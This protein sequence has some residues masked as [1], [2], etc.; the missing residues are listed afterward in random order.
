M[1][2]ILFNW[3][4]IHVTATIVATDYSPNRKYRAVLYAHSSLLPSVAM[5][6]GGGAKDAD[7]FAVVYDSSGSALCEIPFPFAGQG[8]Q[9]GDIYWDDHKVEIKDG[10]CSLP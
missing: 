5:P 9:R 2:C 1:A 3:I 4:F 10:T 6:G 7:G 8:F